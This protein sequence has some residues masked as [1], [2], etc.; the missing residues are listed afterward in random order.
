MDELKKLQALYKAGKIKK[1]DYLKQLK[2]LLDGKDI[3]QEEHDEAK[4]YDPEK[5]TGK[6]IYTQEEV[7]G[8]VSRKAVTL[9]RK[10]LKAA[11]V[12]VDVP[13]KELLPKVAELAKAG[14]DQKA[15][16]ADEKEVAQ[17]RKDAAK[18]PEL[19]KGYKNLQLENAV[20]KAAGKYNP[21]NPAQVVRA[22]MADY[23]GLIEY[24]DIT[25]EVNPQSIGKAIKRIAENEPNLF[26][27][28]DENGSDENGGDTG[29]GFRSK[30]PGGPG[31]K[32]D[33]QKLAAKKAEAL[34]LMGIK[35]PQ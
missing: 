34:E 12:N 17:L 23:H 22:L 10:A 16:S 4:D 24:D 29:G 14:T 11:G 13:N 25:G 7:D 18:V 6:A 31:G 8:M 26:K 1:D 21:H 33:A 9:V 35:K 27:G 19:E 15:P 28:A 32:P 30:P 3:T 20:L 5:D 2:E